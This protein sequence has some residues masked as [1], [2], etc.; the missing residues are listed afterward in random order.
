MKRVLLLLLLLAPIA[1][2]ARP[3][4]ALPEAYAGLGVR[5]YDLP[6]A[7]GNQYAGS[8]EGGVDDVL[9]NIGAGLRIDLPDWKP[10]AVV[11]LR[12]SVF[13]IPFVRIIAGLGGGVERARTGGSSSLSWNG[14]YELFA[15]ARFS[16]GLPYLAVN[17]GGASSKYGPSGFQMFSTITLGVSL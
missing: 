12:Y 5:S 10:A 7:D 13:K 8:L 9:S 4:S 3:A 11:Q 1:L 17:L 2:A 6:G 16:L 15:G 14:T